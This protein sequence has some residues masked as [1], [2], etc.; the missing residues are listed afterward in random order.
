MPVNELFRRWYRYRCA[1]LHREFAA[2]LWG[3]FWLDDI[4][5]RAAQLSYYFLLSL[6]PLLICLSALL[7]Y[8]FAAETRLEQ[9]LLEYL[10]SMMPRAAFDIVRATTD[11]LL[12]TRGSGK[13][14]FGLLVALWLASSGMEA[15]I[16]GLNVAFQVEE[17]RPWWRRRMV[18]LGLTVTVALLAGCGLGLALAGG[19]GGKLLTDFIGLGEIWS[20]LWRVAQW[21]ASMLFLLF[22]I[23][24]VYFLGPNLKA[25]RRGQ[26]IL[27]GA[28]VA[29]I[30]WMTASAGLRVYLDH[31]STFGTTYGSLGAVIALLLWLYLTGAAL[32]LGAEINSGVQARLRETPH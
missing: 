2:W 18:A 23:A 19:I 10:G 13:L 14:S 29:L 3:R 15:V 8:F 17:A 5:G 31:F 11:D 22:A 9:R 12:R 7:G 28:I 27:P 24:L 21:I 4:P 6:F 25:R 20:P 16:E 26:V 30:G 1:F 32:L